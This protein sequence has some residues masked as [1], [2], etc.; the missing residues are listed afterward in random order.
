MGDQDGLAVAGEE[1]EIGLPVAGLATVGGRGRA[2][3]DGDAAADPGHCAAATAAASGPAPMAEA[4]RTAAAATK[5]TA[6][7][8]MWYATLGPGESAHQ[9][10]AFCVASIVVLIRADM[11][12]RGLQMARIQTDPGFES[13]PQSA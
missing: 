6:C 7:S 13:E 4:V 3:M 2:L 11:S 1:H 8:W 10:A 9:G 12:P 5:A